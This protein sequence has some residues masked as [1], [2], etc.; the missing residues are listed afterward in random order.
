[1]SA[2]ALPVTRP[3]GRLRSPV[4]VPIFRRLSI[5]W[6]LTLW[7]SLILGVTLATFSLIVYWYAENEMLQDTYRASV[8]RAAQV[9]SVLNSWVAE[10][11]YL[12]PSASDLLHRKGIIESSVDPFKDPGV[13][14]RVRI[15]GPN[16]VAK[17][18]STELSE[19]SRVPDDRLYIVSAE[20]GRITNEVLQT[21]EGP[22]NVYTEPVYQPNGALF[23]IVQI[24]TSLQHSYARMDWLAR[25]LLMGTLLGTALAL[26][27]GAAI[28][29]VALAPIDA[30]TRTAS[31]INRT[32]DLGRRIQSDGAPDEIGRLAV[33]V[34]EMLDR[35]QAMFDRQRQLLADVSH[36]LR[37]PLTT[38]R[39]ELDLLKRSG[40]VDS[41]G[42]EAM[43]GEAARMSRLVGDLL[44]LAQAD[45]GLAIERYPV[46]LEALLVD[47]QRQARVLATDPSQVILGANEALI[48]LGDADR[49][50]QLLLNLAD[51]ALKHNPPGTHVTLS[52][53]RERNQALLEVADDGHGIPTED[54]PHVF[55]RFY[56]VDK[57][58]SRE[59]GGTG[60][61]LSIVQWIALAHGGTVEVTSAP[62]QGTR[63]S[64]RL[65]LAD[66]DALFKP[67]QD[68]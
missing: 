23:G 38:I 10:S 62:G 24:Y 53:R 28:A 18:S 60:L 66:E 31:Q 6:R 45:V 30:I 36:E 3:A 44:L 43:R 49:L 48:V 42:L 67:R 17:L 46:A 59:S 68:R 5:R 50:R 58:R 47:V 65:P 19:Y 57:A 7:Y 51:N 27:V 20:H 4:H 9:E 40:R 15:Y 11:R 13:G 16:G 41:E 8:G 54:L 21:E 34:N 63:F 61:G 39:G 14:V 29:Q 35:I 26:V 55:E 33:T 52:L 56:R 25:V 2:P 37:T 64:I 1:M 22:F 32:Q 12:T